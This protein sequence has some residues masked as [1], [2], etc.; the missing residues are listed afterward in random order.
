[1]GD[2]GGFSRLSCYAGR[3]VNG[4][5]SVEKIAISEQIV[6][7]VLRDLGLKDMLLRWGVLSPRGILKV[8]C[9]A[10]CTLVYL[11]GSSCFVQSPHARTR[12]FRRL[13]AGYCLG[14]QVG[15][16]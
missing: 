16:W 11:Q 13:R 9:M 15:C 10:I 2:L 1:M 6:A 7:E 3:A 14:S 5:R 4:S 8:P 12:T